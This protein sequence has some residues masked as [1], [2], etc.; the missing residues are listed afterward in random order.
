MG[1]RTVSIYDIAKLA[2]VS[3]ATVS[4]VL[5][6]KGRVSEKT[7][8]Y[9]MKIAQE[10]GYIPNFAAKSLREERT[11]TVGIITPDVSNDYFSSIVLAVET[12]LYNEGYTCYICDTANDPVREDRYISSLLRKQVDGFVF[13]GGTRLTGKTMLPQGMPAVAIDRDIS[14]ISYAPHACTFVGNDV[15][16]LVHDMT[17]KLVERGCSHIAFLSSSTSGP[18][19]EENCRYGGYVDALREAGIR[20]D[21]N[22]VLQGPHKDRSRIEAQRMVA[23]C[24]DV[25]YRFDGITAIGDRQAL[26]AVEELRRRSVRIGDEVKVIGMDNSLYSRISSPAIS[27]VERNTA[28]MASRAVNALLGLLRDSPT[29]KLEIIVPYTIIERETTLGPAAS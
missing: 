29:T 3:A 18:Y 24:L 26:G 1:K 20:L 19:T 27:T 16:K 21:K 6:N 17:L 8:S 4:N 9:V 13:V 15:R 12:L 28:T 14:T 10:Q 22:I 7:R 25:G 11:N 23:E 5:N 2:G